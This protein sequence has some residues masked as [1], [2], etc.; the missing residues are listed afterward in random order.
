MVPLNVKLATYA[1]LLKV[2]AKIQQGGSVDSGLGSIRAD[3]EAVVRGS[4][5]NTHLHGT[6]VDAA[7]LNMKNPSHACFANKSVREICRER[8]VMTAQMA[9]DLNIDNLLVAAVVQC[10]K[11]DVG[12]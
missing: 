8:T 5:W 3:I 6:K 10:L 11:A 9:R 2:A 7:K 4:P 1:N 12:L